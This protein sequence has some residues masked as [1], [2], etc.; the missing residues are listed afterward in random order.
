MRR[1]I[2]AAF[3]LITIVAFGAGLAHGQ[4]YP[5]KP[6]TMV[7]PY[8]AG[9]TAEVLGRIFAQQL[10]DV[11][12]QSIVVEIKA[13]AGSMIGAEY[14]AKIAKPDGYTILFTGNPIAINVAL[15]NLSFDPVKDLAPVAGIAA[16]PS[17]LVTSATGPYMT[18]A[19]VIKASKTTHLT[20]GSSGP[21]THSHMSG[22]LVKAMSHF[23]MTHVPYKGSGP[24]YP[25]LIAGRISVLFDTSA[26]A[27]GFI[28]GGKVRAL[29]ITS[30]ERSKTTPNIPT[31]AEQGVPGYEA[32]TWFGVFVPSSTPPGIVTHLERAIYKVV[33]S[34]AFASRLDQWA[35]LPLPAEPTAAGFG[36][37]Y[38]NEVQEWEKL[39]RDG[40]V[41]RLD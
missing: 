38:R 17:I 20:F 4:I 19:D 21:G 26:S 32:L 37:F 24:V 33:Q 8:A 25:D 10:G 34:P 29:G 13:G 27:I 41:K 6:I 2:I 9:G 22:E 12:G 40:K 16:F 11:L 36:R 23:D 35:G 3:T 28:N 1:A 30:K 31:I 14:V 7:V 18:L 5:N 15:M 39:V